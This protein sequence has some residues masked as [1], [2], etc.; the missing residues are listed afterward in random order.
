MSLFHR[1]KWRPISAT[2]GEFVI[3][4]GIG[5]SVLLHCKDCGDIRTKTINGWWTLAELTG[6]K[7]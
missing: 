7:R 5:T 6:G 3:L 1:H 4:G 2:Q